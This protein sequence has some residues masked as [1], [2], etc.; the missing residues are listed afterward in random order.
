MTRRKK[1]HAPKR[2]KPKPTDT[3]SD[4]CTRNTEDIFQEAENLGRQRTRFYA[5]NWFAASSVRIRQRRHAEQTPARLF[6]I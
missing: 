1:K 3:G 4:A 5:S 2:L 6:Y